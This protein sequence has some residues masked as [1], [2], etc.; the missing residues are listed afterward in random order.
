MS[1][2]LPSKDDE[3]HQISKP[4]N[5]HKRNLPPVVIFVVVAFSIAVGYLAGAYNLQIMAAIGPVFGQK[6]HAGAIDLSSVQ[7]TYNKLAANFDGKLDMEK[8]IQGANRG[9]VDAAGDDYT[10]YMSPSEATDFNNGLSGNIGGGIGAEIGIKNNQVI[11]VRALANNPASQAGL[12]S[13]DIILQVNDESTAG[14][15]VEKTVGL[16][17]GEVDTTVK[18]KI[19][20]GDEITDYSIVRAIV[21]NPSVESS[22]T[23]GIGMLTIYRF[24]NETGDLAKVA[25][26]NF[27]KQ[28]VRAVILD[29]RSNG[30]GYVDAAKIVAGLWLDN[31]TV[32]VE[33]SG[34][35]VKDTITTGSNTILDGIPT[36]VLVNGGTASA[37]EIVAGALQDYGVAKLI[38]EKT[39]GKGSV[40][41]PLDLDGGALLK[42]TVAKWYTPNGK[43]INKAGIK[44]DVTAEITQADIDNGIDPQINAAKTALGL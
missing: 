11:I 12:Q 40:Q 33:K 43:N 5:K 15:T 35:V 28:G 39:F 24:D 34:N 9:L 2:P 22:V 31:Q 17:R 29:L 36:A 32:V 19:Q 20:R 4:R 3:I 41:L 27:V 38:G 14:W 7:I 30:G 8:L 6:P 16:V 42:V 37:S 23:D 44:P 13:N 10:M 1:E 18:L 25:A 21:N 26:R